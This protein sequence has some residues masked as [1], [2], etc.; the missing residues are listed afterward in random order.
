MRS[1]ILCLFTITRLVAIAALALGADGTLA[2]AQGDAAAKKALN[3]YLPESPPPPPP[4]V[5]NKAGVLEKYPDGST[6]VERETI[7]L[8]DD[9]RINHGSYTEYYQNGQKFAQGTYDRGLYDGKWTFWHDNGQICKEVTFIKGV[10]DGSWS[11]YRADGTE[12]SSKSYKLGKRDGKWVEY[13]D[14]GKTVKV[15]QTYQDGS[16]TGDRITY[17]PNGKM[18]Q[19]ATLKVGKLDGSVLEWDESGRK[20]L[21]FNLVDGKLH[22][23]F[24]RW[25]AAGKESVFKFD[26]GQRV[27]LGQ[28]PSPPAE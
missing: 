27:P 25:D 23:D 15:E 12:Q 4:R 24:R 28:T 9:Q 13:G 18:R 22:G 6:Q 17:F 11:V 19:K 20:R 8:S 16:M 26:M 14:D 10:P 3:I 1:I 5:V 2:L 7:L 21:E